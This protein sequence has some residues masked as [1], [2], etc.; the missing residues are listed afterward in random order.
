LKFSAAAAEEKAKALIEIE[1]L[2]EAAA[3]LQ[4]RAQ[5]TG[6]RAPLAG[7]VNKL[8]INTI[9]GVVSPGAAILE[10]VPSGSAIAI[11]ARVSPKDRAQIW[12]GTKAVVKI[13]AYDFTIYGG[14]DAEVTEISPNVIE[15]KEGEP[16]FRVRLT[17]SNNLGADNPIVPGMMANIDM[18]TSNHSVLQYLLMPIIRLRDEA[19]R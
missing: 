11:E 8:Y 13:T 19:L 7:R 16:Y 15:D 9:G 14:L 1:N 17:A 6:V 3:S 5:R 12:P 4:D 18:L 10:I 2:K